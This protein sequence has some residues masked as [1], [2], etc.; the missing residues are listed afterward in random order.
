MPV[1]PQLSTGALA[2]FPLQKRVSQRVVAN[3]MP[4]GSMVKFLDPGGSSLEWDLQ[5]GGLSAAEASALE[6][7][8]HECEGDLRSFVFVDP[9]SNLVAWSE[10]LSEDAW[11]VGPMLILEDGRSDPLGGTRGYSVRNEGGASQALRQTVNAPAEL[12]YCVSCWLRSVTTDRIIL[13]AGA[14]QRERA[15]GPNWRRISAVTSVP[16]DSTFVRFGLELRAGQAVELFGFQA[17]AQAGASGYKTTGAASGI[18]PEARFGQP[19]I[20]ITAEGPNCYACRIRIV[21]HGNIR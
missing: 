16:A 20:R 5:F 14:E 3:L 8:F 10:D 4:D 12:Q 6:N 13:L 7:F 17:E 18:Y 9:T 19:S 2:Q 21:S 1:F 11:D 15:I